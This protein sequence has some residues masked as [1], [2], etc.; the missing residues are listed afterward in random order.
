MPK[1]NE[2]LEAENAELREQLAG[3]S[4]SNATET[5][6]A[7]KIAESG[8]ALNREQAIAALDN[9]AASDAAAKKAAKK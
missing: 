8:G 7:K 1:T 3:F 9:Q 2:E 4:K 5:A 6:I